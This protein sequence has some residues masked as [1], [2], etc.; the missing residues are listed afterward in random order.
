MISFMWQSCRLVPLMSSI[1]LEFQNSE[2]NRYNFH[3]SWSSPSNMLIMMTLTQ[4]RNQKMVMPSL[5]ILLNLKSTWI[6]MVILKSSLGILQFQL[7]FLVE[8]MDSTK[9]GHSDIS[10]KIKA[11]LNNIKLINCSKRVHSRTKIV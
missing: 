6:I 8:S 5:T 9:K 7:L 4:S 3:T 10:G 1:G 11:V 2:N